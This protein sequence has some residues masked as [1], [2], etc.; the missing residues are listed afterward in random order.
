MKHVCNGKPNKW[1]DEMCTNLF[2]YILRPDGNYAN[3][4]VIFAEKKSPRRKKTLAI[5]LHVKHRKP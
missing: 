1:R 3:L 4:F 5:P 2:M